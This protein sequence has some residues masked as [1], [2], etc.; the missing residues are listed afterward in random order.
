MPRP[1]ESCG[2]VAV[3]PS[4]SPLLPKNATWPILETPKKAQEAFARSHLNSSL[5][6]NPSPAPTAAAHR[7]ATRRRWAGLAWPYLQVRSSEGDK[8]KFSQ[9]Q[10]LHLPFG[11]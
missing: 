7:G 5:G 1:A 3:K 9:E 2:K 8:L 6:T 10:P 11:R 4:P